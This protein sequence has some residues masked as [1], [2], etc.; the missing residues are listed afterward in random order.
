M[1]PDEVFAELLLTADG[2]QDPYSRYSWLHE[3]SP[4]HRGAEGTLFLTRYAD[5]HEVLRNESFGKADRILQRS[6]ADRPDPEIQLVDPDARTMLDLNPPDHTRIRG[7][8]SRAFTPRRVRNLTPHIEALA[9][10]CF[11]TLAAAG[12]VDLLEAVGFPLPVAVIGELVG[13]PRSDWPSFRTL[14]TTS[15]MSLEATATEEELDAARVAAAEIY[16]YFLDLVAKKRAEPADDLLSAMLAVSDDDGDRL[17]E[18]EA[19]INAMLMFAAG[20]ETTTNLIGNGVAALLRHPDAVTA[21]RDDPDL[22]A[23]GVEEMLR[24]DSPVQLDA[25]T[26]LEPASIAGLEV[27][28]GQEVVTLLGAANHDPTHFTDPDRFDVRRDEGPPMSFGSGIHYCLGANLARAEGQTVV[29]GL[30]RRFSSIELIEPLTNRQRLTLR[31]YEAV[32]IRVRE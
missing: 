9:E 4:V 16:V 20:F 21:L 7:L 14:V 2:H 13:V 24:Y 11:D 3:N 18:T 12:E 10:E 27:D 8:V 23:S 6:D 29:S 25:R 28:E 32:P 30:L 22:V 19:I 17:S 15:A 26:A 5:C 31:G 1:S